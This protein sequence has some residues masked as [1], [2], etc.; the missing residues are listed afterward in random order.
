MGQIRAL[1]TARN[2]EGR[3]QLPGRQS[4]SASFLLRPLAAFTDGIAAM[5]HESIL[6]L[7][8]MQAADTISRPPVMAELDGRTSFGAHAQLLINH[9][10]MADTAFLCFKLSSGIHS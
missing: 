6:S 1:H 7:S 4:S 3:P 5:A 10:P 8:R 9:L 2:L